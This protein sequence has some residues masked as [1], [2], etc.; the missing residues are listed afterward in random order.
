MRLDGMGTEERREE[1]ECEYKMPRV[2][3]LLA[4]MSWEMYARAAPPPTPIILKAA[5]D[6]FDAGRRAF[7]N[8]Q[9]E[10]AAVYFE[11]ADRDAPSPEALQSAIRARKD[12]GDLVRAYARG[13]GDVALS[14]R[15]ALW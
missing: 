11:N 9:F 14:Q 2:A 10:N 5:A 8:G 15:K 7:K 6:E 13:L 3:T 12:A 1:R 4:T